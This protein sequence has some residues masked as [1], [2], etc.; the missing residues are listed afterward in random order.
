MNLQGYEKYRDALAYI[1]HIARN[2]IDEKRTYVRKN[3]WTP[4]HSQILKGVLGRNY[5]KVL[6]AGVYLKLFTRDDKYMP[7]S[8]KNKK[9]HLGHSKAI[10]LR[11]LLQK[12]KMV[13][14]IITSPN[15]LQNYEKRK[16][17]GFTK[18]PIIKHLK[19][20]N[21]QLINYN[22][23]AFSNKLPRC[24]T[25]KY[26]RIHSNLTHLDKP[27]RQTLLFN[28]LPLSYIDIPNSQPLF[29]Y[30]LITDHTAPSPYGRHKWHGGKKDL[31]KYRKL[32]E[33]GRL[34]AFV[35]KS[36]KSSSPKRKLKKDLF[37]TL[38]GSN[39]IDCETDDFFERV[40]EGIWNYI[41]WLKKKRGYASLA[42]LLHAIEADFVIYTCCER[43]MI[44]HPEIP[45]FTIHDSIF[46]VSEHA[47]YVKRIMDE[48]FKKININVNLV[49]KEN[50]PKC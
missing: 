27:T 20:Y 34:Y 24:K 10:R 19:N 31:E 11:P 22:K 16:K 9:T 33:G 21:T 44:E 13:E 28:S 43:I 41:R 7:Q 1:V 49:I 36:M 39:Y 42:H 2:M 5:K 17:E 18:L 46:T 37:H 3:K 26:G 47:E 30:K 23:T 25:N 48:E 8:P 12:G 4:L 38:Y 45:I 40:F 29:L 32:V 15:I 14:N 6:D 50:K 35:R